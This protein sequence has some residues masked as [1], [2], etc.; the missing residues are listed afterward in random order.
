MANV[1]LGFAGAPGAGSGKDTTADI[2]QELTQQNNIK[3][4]RTSFSAALRSCVETLTEGAVLARNT[5]STEGKAALLPEHALGT[6]EQLIP[7]LSS[8]FSFCL[9]S[10]EDKHEVLVQA[11]KVLL[12]ATSTKSCSVGRLLQVLGTDVARNLFDKNIWVQALDVQWSHE[13]KRAQDH[14]QNL[15]FLVTDIRFENEVAWLKAKKHPSSS[16]PLTRSQS[17]L[18][19]VDAR[20]RFLTKAGTESGPLTQDG[21]SRM[22]ESELGLSALPLSSFDCLMNNNG[23][24]DLL[25]KQVFHLFQHTSIHF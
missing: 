2:V 18:V 9:N 20:L 7:R 8:A 4:V 24:L 23:D 25:R 3:C 5:W 12:E 22:H 10:R 13:T 1:I 6:P 11:S 19:L 16:N 21:R 17:F 15:I 14:N